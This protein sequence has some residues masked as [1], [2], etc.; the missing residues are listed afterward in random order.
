VVCVTSA[1]A[2]AAYLHVH[3]GADENNHM[4]SQEACWLTWPGLV[5][6]VC[7]WH[8][9]D[10]RRNGL[11]TRALAGQAVVLVSLFVRQWMT[12]CWV[13]D[14]GYG[15]CVYA[16]LWLVHCSDRGLHIQFG[17]ADCRAHYI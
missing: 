14:T 6:V 15:S 4:Q 5:V 12:M 7:A 2:V 16:H 13:T 9:P 1:I 11:M 8:P 3:A 10:R 17:T